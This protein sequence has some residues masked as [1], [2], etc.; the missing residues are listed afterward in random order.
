MP[1]FALDKLQPWLVFSQDMHAW[2]W[3]AAGWCMWWILYAHEIPKTTLL[4]A[5]AGQHTGVVS[6]SRREFAPSNIVNF[7]TIIV[8]IIH[9]LECY[10]IFA[11]YVSHASIRQLT[12]AYVSHVKTHGSR[13][14]ISTRPAERT[15]PPRLGATGHVNWSD[16]VASLLGVGVGQ[17]PLKHSLEQSKSGSRFT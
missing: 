12:M 7:A 9:K 1:Q 13:S 16:Q 5:I 2:P 17:Q 11:L 4:R 6:V 10:A 14:H 15:A 3:S 8:E